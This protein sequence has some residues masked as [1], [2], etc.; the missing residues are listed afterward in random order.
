MAENNEELT[1]FGVVIKNDD[2]SDYVTLDDKA[3]KFVEFKLDTVEENVEDRSD[4]VINVIT[5]K[6]NITP[7]TKDKVR[8]L[9]LWAKEKQRNKVYKSVEVT[10]KT[11]GITLREYNLNFAFCVDYTETF[12]SG[13]DAKELKQGNTFELIISQRK[14][15]LDG[16]DIY[17]VGKDE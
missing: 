6:G 9:A 7:D 8:K 14:D 17:S 1:G 2:G 13:R 16:L 11:G 10:L 3:V 5:I 12:R 4:D 15:D